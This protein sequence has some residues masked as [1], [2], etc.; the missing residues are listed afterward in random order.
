MVETNELAIP[1]PRALNAG[2]YAL[3]R[4]DA[5]VAPPID[6]L[7][8]AGE[9]RLS[10]EAKERTSESIAGA[11]CVIIMIPMRSVGTVGC[12]WNTGADRTDLLVINYA[13]L[14]G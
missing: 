12:W 3:N 8:R 5:T 14:L 7:A 13:E 9:E 1:F 10:R 11:I 6:R 2:I 4:F